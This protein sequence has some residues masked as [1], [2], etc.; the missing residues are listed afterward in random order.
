MFGGIPDWSVTCHI[1]PK[2][3]AKMRRILKML[4][5]RDKYV[6]YLGLVISK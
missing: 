6:A 1:S 2:G 5:A 4:Y 3:P